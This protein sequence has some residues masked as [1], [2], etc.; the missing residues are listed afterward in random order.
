MEKMEVEKKLDEVIEEPIAEVEK[1]VS[2][3]KK[4]KTSKWVKNEAVGTKACEACGAVMRG[5]AFRE[6]FQYCPKCGA[7][8]A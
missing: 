1:P 6:D 3:P 5:W 7:K 2:K 8:M 4:E